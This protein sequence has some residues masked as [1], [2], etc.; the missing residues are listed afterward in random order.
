MMR[1]KT[2]F[3]QDMNDEQFDNEVVKWSEFLAEAIDLLP[4]PKH[5]SRKY[6]QYRKNNQN[7]DGQRKYKQSSNPERATKR[8]RQKRREKFR[9]Q[10]TQYNYYN[11]RRKAIR[12]VLNTNHER[13]KIPTEEIYKYFSS[14][15]GVSNDMIRD[16]YPSNIKELD[17]TEMNDIF[18]D[19]ITRGEIEVAINNIAVDTSPGPNHIIIRLIKDNVA[20]EILSIIATR[21]LKTGMVPSTFK[22]ARTILIYKEGD[23]LDIKNWRPITICSVLRRVS[24]RV[25]D[26]RLREFVVFNPNQRGFTNSSGTHINTAILD[27]ILSET[28]SNKSDVTIIFLDIRKAFDNVGHRHLFET[29]KF[30]PLPIKLLHLQS[31]NVIHIQTLNNL[32]SY[33]GCHAGLSFVTILFNLAINHVLNEINEISIATQYGFHLNSSYDL[34]TVLGSLTT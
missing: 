15:H 8:D 23:T 14:T 29:L 9:Y 26:R 27:S 18:A 13:C 19:T 12:S 16:H 7:T 3:L 2:I 4:G 1:W 34:I 32:Y 24:Q 11:Q 30:L 31:G 5:P 28:K 17:R 22:K 25:I 20:A 33:K 6:Y 21:M 10:I